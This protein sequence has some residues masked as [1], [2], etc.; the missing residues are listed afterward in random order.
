MPAHSNAPNHPFSF[1]EK[2]RAFLTPAEQKMA[3]YGF[4]VLGDMALIEVPAALQKK[5]GK[6]ARTLLDTHLNLSR[7]YEKVGVHSGKYR[8]ERIKW[9]AG[10]QNPVALAREWG[11]TLRVNP[12]EV[13]YSAR[14]GTERQRV[15][16][17]IKKGQS[18][19]VFFAGVGPYAILA[20]KHAQP[21]H[22]LALEWN[23]KAIPF[24]RE[25]VRANKVEKIVEIKQ[26]DVKKIHPNGEFDHVIM[27]APDT[28]T[29]YLSLAT[30][31]MAKK[32][33]LIHCYTFVP[34][35]E[36]D[37]AAREKIK[38]ALGTAKRK[39]KI[40][41]IR[42]VNDF[43]AAR[44]QVCVLIRVAALSPARKKAHD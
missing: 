1:R 11:V 5:A 24:L 30:K 43:S 25:N 44:M 13:Y 3:I 2:V 15:V 42:K 33:G 37:S 4:D 22:V 36:M 12:G 38:K 27:P 10:P 6:I 31:W 14:L 17:Q 34:S 26:G 40:V 35:A 16:S 19:A 8:V 23:P 28:A 29:E 39:W 20:A 41:S 7:V 21:K 9:L 18:V 32:G